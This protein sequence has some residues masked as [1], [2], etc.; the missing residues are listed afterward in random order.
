[1]TMLVV[2]ATY[3]ITALTTLVKTKPEEEIPSV[4]LWSL[5]F[6]FG[7]AAVV[8]NTINLLV[9]NKANMVSLQQSLLLRILAVNDL[10]TGVQCIVGGYLYLS[11]E[12][13][14]LLCKV[15]GLLISLCCGNSSI[16]LLLVAIDKY[17]AILNPLQ[18]E[19]MVTTFRIKLFSFLS[20]L[21]QLLFL[22]LISRG[23]SFID[24]EGVDC[25]K[26]Y[27]NCVIDF[28]NHERRF[29]ILLYSLGVVYLPSFMILA[30]YFYI[31]VI[32]R[33]QCKRILPVFTEDSGALQRMKQMQWK[34]FKLAVII[35][36]S[37][38]CPW[39][40]F[41]SLELYQAFSEMRVPLVI[42]H[43]AGVLTVSN[44]W[45]NTF[46]YFVSF[47]KYRST[48][49]ALLG[50]LVSVLLFKCSKEQ[51]QKMIRRSL[52]SII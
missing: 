38:S 5:L 49:G 10:V 16:T 12:E 4:V 17:I 36:I 30:I 6:T 29:A 32:S 41:A 7:T 21:V 44:S 52:E 8:G 39:L 19:R 45:W 18:Y 35:T 48:A 20:L 43:I 2:E 23:E 27:G 31:A 28:H 26:A 15:S 11:L 1:M 14:I 25:I 22:F 42:Q 51:D 47:Q 37:F 13:H 9:L 40:L 46:V 33:R 24:L 34:G 50:Q 3:P